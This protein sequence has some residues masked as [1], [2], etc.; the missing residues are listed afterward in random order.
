MLDYSNVVIV[1]LPRFTDALNP[2]WTDLKT[3]TSSDT[4]TVLKRTMEI[5]LKLLKSEESF[6]DKRICRVEEQTGASDET[7]RVK[8]AKHLTVSP[9][10]TVLLVYMNYCDFSEFD[11]DDSSE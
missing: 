10:S 11:D 5:W 2:P 7:K 4:E 8:G 9:S 3:E 6:I 1:F